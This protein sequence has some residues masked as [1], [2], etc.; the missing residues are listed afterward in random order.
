MFAGKDELTI[1]QEDI[2]RA[3][4]RPRVKWAMLIDLQTLQLL[5]GVH[6]RVH[7]RTEK[8]AG[9]SCT[10]LSTKKKRASSPK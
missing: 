7:S 6:R 3:L 4:R 8:P 1:I 5:Q 9:D 10:G 2:Q